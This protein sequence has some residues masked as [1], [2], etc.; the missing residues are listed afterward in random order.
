MLLNLIFCLRQFSSAIAKAGR[1]RKFVVVHE[2]PALLSGSSVVRIQSSL[3][4]TLT[5]VALAVPK[6]PL[7]LWLKR[8]LQWAVR[9][10]YMVASKVFMMAFGT[11]STINLTINTRATCS[12]PGE[13]Q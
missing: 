10:W 5:M 12:F 13:F 4:E 1:F 11:V 9:L 2:R 3:Q 7:S 8:G 6:R